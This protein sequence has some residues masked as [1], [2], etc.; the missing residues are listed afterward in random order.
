[1][2]PA[3]IPF[4]INTKSFVIAIFVFMTMAKLIFIVFGALLHWWRKMSSMKADPLDQKVT[5]FEKINWFVLRKWRN[6]PVDAET[7][8]SGFW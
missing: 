4:T 2:P 6:R 1:M 8:V 7:G 3:V 5:T